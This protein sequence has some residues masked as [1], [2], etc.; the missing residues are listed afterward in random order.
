MN[1]WQFG[2]VG[3][4]GFSLQ[5]YVMLLFLSSLWPPCIADADIIFYGR[6]M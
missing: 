3:P 5:A 1:E 4:P 2:L 6:P